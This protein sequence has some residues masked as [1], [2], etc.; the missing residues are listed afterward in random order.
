MHGEGVGAGPGSVD[1]GGRQVGRL[2]RLVADFESFLHQ[3]H[4]HLI[5]LRARQLGFL[6]QLAALELSNRRMTI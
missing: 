1:V 3:V 4:H 5:E 6:R 2:Q